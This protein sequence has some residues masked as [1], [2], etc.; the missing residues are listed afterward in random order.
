VASYNGESG[1]AMKILSVMKVTTQGTIRTA[2]KNRLSAK[3]IREAMFIVRVA[4]EVHGD[5]LVYFQEVGA[6]HICHLSLQS[7][8]VA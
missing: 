3:E 8:L 6:L 1:P 5:C 4:F 7:Y 2:R